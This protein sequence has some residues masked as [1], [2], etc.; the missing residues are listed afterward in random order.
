MRTAT[1]KPTAAKMPESGASHC[2]DAGNRL[3]MSHESGNTPTIKSSASSE[4]FFGLMAI[5]LWGP[6][7]ELSGLRGFSRRSARMKGWAPL[8]PAKHG[9]FD[10]DYHS[11][12]R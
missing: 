3:A 5:P 12:A 6:T 4:V 2:H 10:G 8:R 9:T 7:F 11:S 1:R